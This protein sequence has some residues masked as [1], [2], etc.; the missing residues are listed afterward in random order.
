MRARAGF[1]VILDGEDGELFV[2]EALDGA[3]VEI[4]F[5]NDA[6]TLFELFRVGGE[7]V[8][9][10]GDA[11]DARLQI[12]YGLIAATVAELELVGACAEGVGNHLVAKANAKHGVAGHELADGFVGVGDGGRIARAIGQEDA[13]G[14]TLDDGLGSG[15]GGDDVHIETMVGEFAKDVVLG[16]EIV[17][18]D[19]LA[20]ARESG[21]ADVCARDGEGGGVVGV[22]IPCEG[23]AA[24]DF[25]NVVETDQARPLAGTADGFLRAEAFGAE[26]ALAGALNAELLRDG[27]GIYAR[28]AWNAVT[29]E[30]IGKGFCGAPVGVDGADLADDKASHLWGIALDVGE[31]DTVVADL[32]GSHG[33]DL[34]EIGGIGDNLLIARHGGIKNGFTSDSALGT[35]GSAYEEAAVFEGE[36]G[37]RGR[38]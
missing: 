6:A 38:H 21:G 36:N 32:G 28:D 37:L 27:A 15:I 23:S 11:D 1:G 29:G 12:F 31:V 19:T 34:T 33:N 24:G 26:A 7:A 30:P 18:D 20:G 14:V 22:V 16:A 17:G 8:I 2:A 3:V 13:L 4:D 9:L 25:A 5:G 10:G 35:E